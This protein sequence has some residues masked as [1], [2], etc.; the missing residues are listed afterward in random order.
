MCVS[1]CVCVFVCACVHA[2]VRVCVH[3]CKH[4]HVQCTMYVYMGVVHMWCVCMYFGVYLKYMYMYNLIP[5]TLHS[6]LYM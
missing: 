3:V 1:M 4:V 2:C 6:L 5:T